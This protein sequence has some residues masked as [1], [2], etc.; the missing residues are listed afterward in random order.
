MRSSALILGFLPCVAVGCGNVAATTDAAPARTVA[1]DPT[2]HA[3]SVLQN[4]SFDA[5]T[6]AWVQ[7]PPAPPS[8]L[9]G[10]PLINPFDGTKAACLGG[11]DGQ[12]NTIFQTIALPAGATS[13]TLNGQ[14]CI[15]TKETAAVDTDTLV[16][17][18]VDGN[19]VIASLGRLS[20]Q[21]GTA[22][23]QFGAFTLQGQLA[24][25]PVTATLR[26]RSNLDANNTTSFY[27]DA[28]TLNAGCVP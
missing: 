11:V 9:C 24:S 2:T 16:F 12:T 15:A 14:K 23:C 18:I 6:P 20:N 13:L 7:D 1:C 28:L 21:Q 19:V 10:Q 4:G 3:V 25:A 5:P 8:F 17:D 22:D 26:I 27:L